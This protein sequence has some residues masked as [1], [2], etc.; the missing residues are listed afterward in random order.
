MDK[1]SV[2]VPSYNNA[3]WLPQCLESLLAQT[4]EN[5]EII[6]VDDGSTD[7]TP[8]VLEAFSRKDS[9]ILALRQEN[10]GVTAARLRGVAE[11]TGD[12][13]GFVDGD[14]RV[15]PDLFARLL[16][17]AK[18]EDA[19]IS[20]CGYQLVFLDGRREQHGGTGTRLVQ[21]R[22]QAMETLLEE[23]LVKPG[24]WNKLFRR[25]LFSGLDDWMDRSVKNNEDMLMNYYLF[26]QAEKAVFEDWCGYL[27]Q[28]RTGSASRARLNAHKI[29]D[30]IRVRQRILDECEPELKDTARQALLRC[31]LYVYAQLTIAHDPAFQPDKEKVRQMIAGEKA[32]YH[33]LTTRNQLLCQLIRLC[34]RAFSLAFR[35]Y[36]AVVLRGN[37]E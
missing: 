4:Y 31:L 14:D 10:S 24:L 17:N 7:D 22:I 2:V 37:Y 18:K 9:K 16:E 29:Y 23:K 26:C 25:E 12:W 33:L 13:I 30:P 21:T 3:P 20:H 19:D 5:L 32:H 28:A 8:A 35:G 36:V 1:I 6:V 15:E 27:Y 11:A 34:P